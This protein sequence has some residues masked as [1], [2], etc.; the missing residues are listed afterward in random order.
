MNNKH[1]DQDFSKS[2]HNTVVIIGKLLL[3]QI[4]ICLLGICKFLH[5]CDIHVKTVLTQVNSQHIE[6]KQSSDLI[7][8]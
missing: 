2:K 5:T 3:N 8:V 7:S 6:A 1:T 4:A